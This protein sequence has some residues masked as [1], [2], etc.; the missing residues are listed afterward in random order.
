MV[1]IHDSFEQSEI[2]KSWLKENGGAIVLGLVLAFGS[3]FGLKQWQLWDTNKRQQASA[4][5]ELMTEL[6]TGGNLDV[7]VSNYETLKAEYPDSAYTSLAA[8][9][10]AKARLES[11]QDDLA[12]Q[13]L[14][15]AMNNAKPE[16][17]RIVARARLARVRVDQGELD[18][19]LALLDA[20]PSDVG[21]EALFAEIKGDIYMLKGQLIEAARYYQLALDSL[22]SGTGNRAFLEVKLES[23]GGSVTSEDQAS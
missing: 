10:M 16:A 8:L 5:F 22:K 11:G 20:S 13:L 19:A 1:E 17:V 4:E 7:A 21:F 18:V 23:V 2:V 6:L 3:L 9:H 14:D 12:A 15:Q